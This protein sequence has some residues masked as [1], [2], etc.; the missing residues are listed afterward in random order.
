MHAVRWAVLDNVFIRCLPVQISPSDNKHVKEVKAVVWAQRA[1]KNGAELPN[2]LLKD[3]FLKDLEPLGW[4]K[5]Q[6][7]CS[8]ISLPKMPLPRPS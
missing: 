7:L 5:M 1:C 6:A 4:V 8:A 2:Q 3:D